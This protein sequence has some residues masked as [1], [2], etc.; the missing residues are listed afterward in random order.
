MSK[1][2]ISK[3]IYSTMKREVEAAEIS[4]A[5]AVT[6]AKNKRAAFEQFEPEPD[7]RKK[8]VATGAADANQAQGTGSVEA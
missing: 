4:A 1:I 2:L 3:R 8:L 6:K 5:N 7:G